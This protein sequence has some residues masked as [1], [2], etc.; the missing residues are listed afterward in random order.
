MPYCK[1]FA[2]ICFLKTASINGF[3]RKN[4]KNPCLFCF[5]DEYKKVVFFLV[6][7][8]ILSK[9]FFPKM[10]YQ[11]LRNTGMQYRLASGVCWMALSTECEY[12]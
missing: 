6:I 8:G 9:T 7:G 3:N 10:K 1:G 5:C 11:L 4:H 12:L 2:A